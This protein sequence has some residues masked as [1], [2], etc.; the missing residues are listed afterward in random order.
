MAVLPEVEI[1]LPLAGLIDKEAEAARL[2]KTLADL[3]SNWQSVAGEAPQRVVHEP[4]P[5]R[6]RGAAAR[7]GGRAA[8]PSVGGRS[9][10]ELRRIYR[11]ALTGCVHPLIIVGDQVP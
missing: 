3:E 11:R 1:I 2:R 8:A 10:A 5:C 9:L 6:G 7:Q 4:C